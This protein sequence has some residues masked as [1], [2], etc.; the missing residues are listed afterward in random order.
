MRDLTPI[1]RRAVVGDV[2]VLV[3]MTVAGFATHLT[4]GDLGRMAVTG[5]GAL[6]AWAAVAVPMGVYRLEV[7]QHP[8]GVWKVAWAWL[9]AAPLATFLRGAALARDI[10]PVFVVVVILTNGFALVLWRIYLGWS[11]TRRY[12]TGSTSTNSPR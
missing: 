9:I 7:I 6:A 1:Q 12:R 11:S 4:L 10:P 3:L 2:V 8:S 5:V